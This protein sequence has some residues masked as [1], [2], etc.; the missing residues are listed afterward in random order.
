MMYKK[1]I[2]LVMALLIAAMIIPAV[3][4]ANN[5][6]HDSLY[7]E[8]QGDSQ[9]NGTLN[10]TQNISVTG[11][12]GSGNNNLYLDAQDAIYLKYNGG[13]TMYVG[14]LGSTDLNVSGA[15]YVQS[16]TA[17]VNGKQIC[18]GNIIFNSPIS[19]KRISPKR[20][21]CVNYVSHF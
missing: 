12:T 16:S 14:V 4:A 7:I 1:S 20:S 8:H 17:T 6:G 18:L 13:G 15:L 9:L 3:F 10:I 21:K 19:C 5:P 11:S 2:I